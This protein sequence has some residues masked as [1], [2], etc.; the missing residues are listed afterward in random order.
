MKDI[1]MKEIYLEAD[2][3]QRAGRSFSR[4]VSL[5]MFQFWHNDR[6][7]FDHLPKRPI[8]LHH[9]INSKIQLP[10][11]ARRRTPLLSIHRQGR[12]I[13]ANGIWVVCNNGNVVSSAHKLFIFTRLARHVVLKDLHHVFLCIRGLGRGGAVAI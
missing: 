1:N 7:I 6:P 5:P 9:E 13:S 8:P 11:S 10:T 3:I 2:L 12:L 4:L